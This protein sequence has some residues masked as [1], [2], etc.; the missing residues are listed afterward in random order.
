MQKLLCSQ[1]NDILLLNSDLIH[2]IQ[3]FKCGTVMDA[4]KEVEAI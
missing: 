2:L 1:K 3:M 4:S